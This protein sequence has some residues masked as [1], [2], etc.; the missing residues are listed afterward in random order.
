MGGKATSPWI[1]TCIG[2]FFSFGE[3]LW[4]LFQTDL[5]W[6]STLNFAARMQAFG[7]PTQI[8]SRVGQDSLGQQALLGIQK[9]DSPPPASKR[10]NTHQPTGTVEIQLDAFGNADYHILQSVAYDDII[11]PNETELLVPRAKVL[12]FETWFS[13]F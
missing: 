7:H 12:Y 4:D 3:V 11:L 5:P 2:R 1:P 13:A 10:T 6:G 8:I 9:L